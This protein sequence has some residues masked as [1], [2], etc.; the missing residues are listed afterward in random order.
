MDVKDLNQYIGKKVKLYT[1]SRIIKGTIL[2]VG[3]RGI[4]VRGAEILQSP[5]F[6]EDYRNEEEWLSWIMVNPF[7]VHSVEIAMRKKYKYA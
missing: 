5:S 6:H 7:N 2:S 3:N 4:E 1:S